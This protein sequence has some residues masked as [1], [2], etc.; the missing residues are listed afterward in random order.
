MQKELRGKDPRIAVYVDDIGITA[1]RASKEDMLRLYAK[2]KTLLEQ[3]KNQ[4]LPLND[5]KTKVIFHSGETYGKDGNYLGKWAFEH[6]GLQMKRNSVTIGSKTRGK[7]DR[8]TNELRKS[9]KK[10]QATKRRRGA[11][12]H[13]KAYIERENT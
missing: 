7:L 3:D 13:Y 12:L 1:S 11:F 9:D 6:L 5:D 2:I 10:D 4:P 8:A